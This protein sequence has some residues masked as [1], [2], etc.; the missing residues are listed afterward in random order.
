MNRYRVVVELYK[1]PK[2]VEERA[3]FVEAGNK[4]LAVIRALD[5][6]RKDAALNEVFKKARSVE[7]SK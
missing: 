1:S 2:D 7:F 4:K 6:L 5:E 3:V